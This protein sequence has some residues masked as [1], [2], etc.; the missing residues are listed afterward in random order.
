MA[1][2]SSKVLAVPLE[3]S[4]V[5]MHGSTEQRLCEVENRRFS[6]LSFLDLNWTRNAVEPRTGIEFPMI[7]DNILAGENKSRLTSEV[8][9]TKLHALSLG[10]VS[11]LNF[12]NN[13]QSLHLELC[14]SI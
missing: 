1:I 2:R 3:N 5:Q 13:T 9:M 14:Y 7:L 12:C 8:N 4:G 6:G 10:V 11:L